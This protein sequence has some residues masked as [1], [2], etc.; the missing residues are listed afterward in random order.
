MLFH[1]FHLHRAREAQDLGRPVETKIGERKVMRQDG[2]R[3]WGTW[4]RHKEA[5]RLNHSQGV[6][7]N[8][9]RRRGRR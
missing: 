4:D 2:C 1:G 8:G 6:K 3:Q 9:R 5:K 7:G